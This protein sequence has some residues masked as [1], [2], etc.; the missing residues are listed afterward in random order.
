MALILAAL[1]ALL[2]LAMMIAFSFDPISNQVGADLQVSYLEAA[3]QFAHQQDMYHEPIEFVE[4]H[5]LYSPAFA[6][7][8]I[9]FTWLPLQATMLIH[10]FL[11]LGVYLL[12]FVRWGKI[13]QEYGLEKA[14]RTLIWSLPIWLLFSA[15]W[16]DLGYL[17]TY[18]ILALLGT[19]LVEAVLKED[20]IPAS[21]WLTLILI[22]KPH[23]AFVLALPLLLGRVR[24]FFK[25]VLG[26]LVGTLAFGLIAALISSPE[27][28]WNQTLGQFAFLARLTSE[29]PWRGPE[30]GFL[31]YSHSVLQTILF[32]TGVTAANMR[33]AQ[34]VKAILLIPLGIVAGRHL[35]RP[36][37]QAGKD[38]PEVALQLAFLLYL[39][40]F[41]WLD[42]VW[43]LSLSIAIFVYLY[44]TIDRP[45]KIL[46][47]IVY[48]PYALLNVWRILTYTAGVSLVG[49]AYF[50][51]DYSAYFPLILV[52]L[53]TLY[54]LLL[55][56]AWQSG[57][58]PVEKG[59][60]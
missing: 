47:M 35:L 27:Y 40:T 57:P 33:I 18:T 4:G 58:R 5:Y 23:W 15:F 54:G 52:V 22:S 24:F 11:H 50:G 2:Q 10:I 25:L 49:D 19:L 41:I 16:D 59:G 7:L 17:N 31:G 48:L 6:M 1:M 26:G 20:L 34:I 51:W 3:D 21:L 55:R 45:G 28:V 56:R 43:E 38:I 9:P 12:L 14:A 60:L 53:L 36:V 44:A 46:L 37:R 42:M 29:Y 32:Y 8:F 39:G 30:D 13:F